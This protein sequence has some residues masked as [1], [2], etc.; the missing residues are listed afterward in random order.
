[1]EALNK[2]NRKELL[3]S[4]NFL[5]D[6]K[7]LTAKVDYQSGI[8]YFDTILKGRSTEDFKAKIHIEARNN[9]LEIILARLFKS[10]SVAIP[11][12]KIKNIFLTNANTPQVIIELEEDTIVLCFNFTDMTDVSEFF[13]KYCY[14][15]F[16]IKKSEQNEFRNKYPYLENYKRKV[17]THR[18]EFLQGTA[19]IIGLIAIFSSIYCRFNIAEIVVGI[20]SAV[21]VF[22][23]FLFLYVTCLILCF[24]I[25]KL[26][27]RNKLGW[28]IFGVLVPNIALIWVAFI[29]PKD[30]MLFDE[31]CRINAERKISYYYGN[32]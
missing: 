19:F 17:P 5:E 4:N 30:K 25:A 32:N 6:G 13:Y 8:E 10:N 26:T 9:G 29:K 14:S 7:S 28:I 11:Y 21:A 2:K 16:R 1:M 20:W 15:K 18:L 23:Y 31:L 22:I 12:V 27:K 3:G 24:K